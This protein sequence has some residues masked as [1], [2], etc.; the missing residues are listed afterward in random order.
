M[1]VRPPAPKGWIVPNARPSRSGSY[2]RR[3][4]RPLPRATP[5]AAARSRGRRPVD[6]ENADRESDPADEDR[7]R[8][9]EDDAEPAGECD[10][11]RS[12][13]TMTTPRP[14]PVTET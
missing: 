7:S 14:P 10:A 2:R 3:S 5:S 11:T 4:P 13:V 12:A 6:D 8:V 1:R 9:V